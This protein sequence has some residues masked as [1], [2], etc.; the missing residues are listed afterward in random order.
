MK[1]GK[2][3]KGHR[4]ETEPSQVSRISLKSAMTNPREV[5]VVMRALKKKSKGGNVGHSCSDYA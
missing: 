1:K 2:E 5:G 3:V 4:K